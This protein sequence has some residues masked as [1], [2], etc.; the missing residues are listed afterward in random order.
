MAR[1][2]RATTR[3]PFPGPKKAL[4]GPL[5]LGHTSF[6]GD[7]ATWP[8][9]ITFRDPLTRWQTTPVGDGIFW[10]MSSSHILILPTPRHNPGRCS[11]LA[12]DTNSA[13]TGALCRQRQRSASH[14]SVVP[15]PTP[16]GPSGFR[17]VKPLASTLSQSDSAIA[18]PCSSSLHGA[19]ARDPFHPAATLSAL[20][21]WRM[22]YERW[23]RRM[24]GWGPRT[25][26]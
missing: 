22:P 25:L 11:H 5:L 23:A 7:I 20:G 9:T 1:G 3:P 19:I 6:N 4:P 18:S 17:S 13:L 16:P 15:L 2:S 14:V 10:I 8:D 21:Q 26:A 24:P 12:N